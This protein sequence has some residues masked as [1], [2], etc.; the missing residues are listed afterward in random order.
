[1]S[2]LTKRQINLAAKIYSLSVLVLYD[3]GGEKSDEEILVVRKSINIAKDKF[4]KMYPTQKSIPATLKQCIELAL[5]GD[6]Q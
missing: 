3:N 2:K 5:I 4:Y 6:R 1:M